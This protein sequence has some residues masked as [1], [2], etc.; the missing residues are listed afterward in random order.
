MALMAM[1][2]ENLDLNLLVAIDALLRRRSVTAAAEELHITQS[3]MSSALKRARLHFE[4]ELFYYDGQRMVPTS[5]GAELEARVPDMVALLRSVSRM[6]PSNDLATLNRHFTIIASDYVAAVYISALTKRLATIAPHV[7]L[8]ILPFTQEAVRQ[9]QR[10][11]LDFLIGPDFALTPQYTAE[12]LFQDRF[13]CVLWKDNPVLATGF[14]ANDFFRSPMVVTNFFLENGKSHFERW[15]EEQAQDIRVAASLPSFLVL[16]HYV[17]GTANIATIHERLV[18]HF[19]GFPD[20]AFVDPPVD[21]PM[22][23]EHLVTAEKHH[24]DSD[25]QLLARVMR[26]VGRDI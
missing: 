4:D 20:L 9:F 3:A 7:S 26:E 12:P 15:L 23:Q 24:H 17:A 6:R 18:P 22:I 14:E 11:V 21:V 19:A 16:P 25:A 5:F 10:G 2:L 1:H 8:S 13:K